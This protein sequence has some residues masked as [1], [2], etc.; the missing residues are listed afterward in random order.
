MFRAEDIASDNDQQ[1]DHVYNLLVVLKTLSA[2]K[3]RHRRIN[4]STRLPTEAGSPV[5]D[6]RVSSLQELLPCSL[7]VDS[8][9]SIQ[10][11]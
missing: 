6:T 7:S 10:Q 8:L 5:L 11:R 2:D 9:V 3:Q 1:Q 4:S